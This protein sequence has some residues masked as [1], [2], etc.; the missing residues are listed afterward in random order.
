MKK[1]SVYVLLVAI[2]ISCGLECGMKRHIVKKNADGTYIGFA[3]EWEDLEN[4]FIDY[5]SIT[6]M[7][8]YPYSYLTKNRDNLNWKTETEDLSSY[9]EYMK[10]Y[11]FHY[12]F[13]IVRDGNHKLLHL[14]RLTDDNTFEKIV[15]TY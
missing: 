15:L 14:F 11:N 7:N 5:N 13:F 10:D 12:F 2:L 3:R 9:L 4:C 1:L 6:K 8:C